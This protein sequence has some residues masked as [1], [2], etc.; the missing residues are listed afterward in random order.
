ML[1]KLMPLP[2]FCYSNFA[3]LSSTMKNRTRF[4]E[5]ILLDRHIFEKLFLS[6]SFTIRA[7]FL[8]L[9]VCEYDLGQPVKFL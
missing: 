3:V 7:Y 1:H 9:L 2:Q 4:C 8:H 5:E 6:W